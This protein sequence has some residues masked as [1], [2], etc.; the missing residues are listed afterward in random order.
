MLAA[1][2]E[3]FAE[4][5][6]AGATTREI[7]ERANVRESHLFQQFPTK[8]A[9][10]EAAVLLPFQEF[11]RGYADDW[12]DR[13][14]DI[15]APEQMLTSYV[16]DLYSVVREQR[17]LLLALPID[18][19]LDEVDATRALLDRLADMAA[20]VSVLHHLVFDP[21]I[22]VRLVLLQVTTTALFADQLLPGR[23]QEDIV[24]EL[25]A[26]IVAGITQRPARP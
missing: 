3:V 22:A 23:D 17:D 20:E 25:A 16:R 21:Q 18:G 26:M 24:A 15:S 14:T 11:L 12:A 5:G 8:Q 10:F 19:L 9:L 13:F 2:R 6:Y 1:A 4:K 7:S